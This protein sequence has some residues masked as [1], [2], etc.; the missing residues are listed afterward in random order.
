MSTNQELLERRIAEIDEAI[1]TLAAE[2]NALQNLLYMQIIDARGISAPNKRSY[3]RI[4]DE[5][6]I[7]QVISNLRSGAGVRQIYRGLSKMGLSIKE[8]TIR[9]HLTR[10]RKRGEVDYDTRSQ[11]WRI[12][13]SGK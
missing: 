6:K 12:I 7:K 9:S 5:E 4:Y 8:S 13:S 2:R 10:M 3:K 11:R 1:H